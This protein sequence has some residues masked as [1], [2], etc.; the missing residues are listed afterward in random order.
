MTEQNKSACGC[1]MGNDCGV[2]IWMNDKISAVVKSRKTDHEPLRLLATM[3]LYAHRETAYLQIMQSWE[4]IHLDHVMDNMKLR[5]GMA[6]DIYKEWK[7]RNREILGRLMP[8][9]GYKT[10]VHHCVCGQWN[11][12]KKQFCPVCSRTVPVI[13]LGVWTTLAELQKQ[14][15][16]KGKE[17]CQTTMENV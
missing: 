16:E 4:G 12:Q 8:S 17:Q 3:L 6:W 15:Q 10:I 5:V 2:A 1:T 7:N 11:D 9:E 13:P 14:H